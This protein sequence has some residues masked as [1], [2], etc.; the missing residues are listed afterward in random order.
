LEDQQSRNTAS[1]QEDLFGTLAP[2]EAKPEQMTCEFV[3]AQ[4]WDDE[5]RLN[6]EKETLGLY[7]TGHPIERYETEL[8]GIISSKIVD[9]NP[10]SNQTMTVA[11]LI[12]AMRTMNTKRGDR[13][14]F[15]TL[16]DRTGRVELA[17]FA[18]PFQQYRDMLAKD[19]LVVVEG[20][21]SIDDYTGGVKMSAQKI[22]DISRAREAFASRLLVTVDHEKAGNGFVNTLA[23]VLT[24]F[25]EGHCPVYLHYLGSTAKAN[26]RLGDHWC[27]HPTDELI[28]RLNELAGESNVRVEYRPQKTVTPPLAEPAFF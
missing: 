22:Y 8:Q 1:G 13:M 14:A 21:V 3:E 26:I 6:G 27:V 28:H 12:V 4:D 19:R 20:D 16:D 18:E 24:P 11:G 15:I 17:V 5:T 7:L 9:L 2:S 25:K 23:N 10:T